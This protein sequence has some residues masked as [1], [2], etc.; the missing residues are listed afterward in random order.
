MK[1]H[2]TV[3]TTDF[4]GLPALKL[5]ARDGGTATVTL[6]GAQVVSWTSARGAERLYVSEASAFEAGKA[7]RGGVPVIFPRFGTEKAGQPAPRHGFARTSTWT[8]ET[9]R[10]GDD[11]AMATLRLTDDE[12]S[13]DLWPHNFRADLSVCLT[14]ATLE[15]ELEV[16]NT[17]SRAF[18]FTT[19]LHTYLRVPNVQR[20]Q[21]EGLQ[22]TRF[23]DAVR[24]GEHTDRDDALTLDG[25]VDRVYAGVERP[26]LFTDGARA[27]EVRAEGFG[28]VVVW[29]PWSEKGAALTDL[30][31]DGWKQFLCVE[32][33]RV[34]SPV[35]LSGGEDWFGRVA[36]HAVR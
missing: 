21:V 1:Q 6:H 29:N 25:E 20:A 4:H 33:G 7:I 15:I 17:G 2:P 3:E 35:R 32:S 14:D 27:V 24:G 8:L 23:R 12:S 36:Y 30:A 26:L 5:T 34:L 18:E 19:A 10:T 28:D 11:F 16:E 31:P 22:G 9:S 13:F